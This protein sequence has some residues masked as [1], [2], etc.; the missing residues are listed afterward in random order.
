MVNSLNKKVDILT[1][2]ISFYKKLTEKAEKLSPKR[3]DLVIDCQTYM[4]KHH[5]SEA[6][7]ASAPLRKS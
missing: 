1:S 5:G 3:H 7:L 2:E 4:D 6:E